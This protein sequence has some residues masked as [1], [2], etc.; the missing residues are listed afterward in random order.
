MEMAAEASERAGEGSMAGVSNKGDMAGDTM[1]A[2]PGDK[3]PPRGEGPPRG[4]DPWRGEE[5]GHTAEV[6]E[7][8]E[9]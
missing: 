5:R 7:T 6:E 4:E 1:A 8:E 2:V 3:D 9:Y